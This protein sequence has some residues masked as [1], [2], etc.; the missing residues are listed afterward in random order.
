LKVPYCAAFQYMC[1]CY[2]VLDTSYAIS[3]FFTWW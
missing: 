1:V 3:V 2:Q